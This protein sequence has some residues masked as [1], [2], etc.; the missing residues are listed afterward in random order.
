MVSNSY[1]SCPE[2]KKIVTC[3][4]HKLIQ[5]KYHSNKCHNTE[6]C[7]TPNFTFLECDSILL[8]STYCNLLSKKLFD[9]SCVYNDTMFNENAS[10][11]SVKGCDV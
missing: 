8:I 4:H 1:I 5:Y 10:L 6:T 2:Q 3:I 7:E 11:C 9:Q